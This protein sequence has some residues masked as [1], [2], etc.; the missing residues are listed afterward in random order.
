MLFTC[1]TPIKMFRLQ[2][3]NVFVFT[4]HIRL[5]PINCNSHIKLLNLNL[6][7]SKIEEHNAQ[8]QKHKCVKQLKE[9]RDTQ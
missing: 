7:A 8:Y 5:T 6:Q 9:L 4:D 2:N 3:K 1:L